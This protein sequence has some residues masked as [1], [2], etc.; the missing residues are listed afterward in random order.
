M[1]AA[2]SIDQSEELLKDVKLLQQ[3]SID[4]TTKTHKLIQFHIVSVMLASSSATHIYFLLCYGAVCDSP[5][6]ASCGPDQSGGACSMAFS[7]Q[8]SSCS[9]HKYVGRSMSRKHVS[10]ESIRVS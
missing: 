3:S 2:E 7:L 10:K 8:C 4:T 5:P 6:L 1:K 9:L